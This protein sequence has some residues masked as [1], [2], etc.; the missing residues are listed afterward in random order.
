MSWLIDADDAFSCDD[1]L[2]MATALWVNLKSSKRQLRTSSL[3]TN[4]FTSFIVTSMNEPCQTQSQSVRV[5]SGGNWNLRLA[6]PLPPTPFYRYKFSQRRTVTIHSLPSV[7]NPSC[8]LH[9]S[10]TPIAPS[11]FASSYKPSPPASSLGGPFPSS[12]AAPLSSI[13]SILF[14]SIASR[15]S[16]W[17]TLEDLLWVV[18]R[19]RFCDHYRKAFYFWSGGVVSSS[20]LSFPFF[21]S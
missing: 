5:S 17:L 16:S 15:L 3:Q 18:L 2:G 9:S 6:P 7:P 20:A 11:E 13:L 12:I 14:R 8:L 1:Q 19:C 10:N 21:C 4:N